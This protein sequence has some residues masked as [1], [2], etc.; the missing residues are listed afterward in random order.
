VILK[1]NDAKPRKLRQ[2]AIIGHER[3]APSGKRCGKLERVRRSDAVGGAELRRRS[4]LGT[5]EL[6]EMQPKAPGKENF[7]ALRQRQI[8]DAIR[9]DQ[10]FEQGDGRGDQLAP[11][12]SRL[13]EERIAFR[14]PSAVKPP[15]PRH[16]A[17]VV[18]DDGAK[19][20]PGSGTQPP[21]RTS[22]TL[23]SK[24]R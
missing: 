13:L 15:R 12:S 2:V 5:I 23:T 8:P 22:G 6:H 10:Q 19:R 20:G 24:P 7:V 4:K 21:C 9:Y 3:L 17:A 18:A 14:A 11:A 16:R 1:S